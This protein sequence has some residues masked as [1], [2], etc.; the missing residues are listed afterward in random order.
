MSDTH[1]TAATMQ[2]LLNNQ[3]DRTRAALDG[4][5]DALLDRDPGGGCMTIRENLRH[6]VNLIAMQLSMMDQPA[7]AVWAAS[8]SR[9]VADYTRAL[10]QGIKALGEAFARHDPEDWFARPATPRDGYWGDEPT[11]HRLSRPFND[12][13]NHLGAIRIVRKQFASPATKTF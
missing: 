5:D 11:L 6:M 4:M 1:P 9:T 8:E 3:A 10:E 2:A 7:D 13:V 12:Y